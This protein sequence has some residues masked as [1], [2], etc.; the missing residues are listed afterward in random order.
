MFSLGISGTVYAQT[1]GYGSGDGIGDSV[2]PGDTPTSLA[3]LIAWWK[4]NSGIEMG[5]HEPR[6]GEC[7][8]VV[9]FRFDFGCNWDAGDYIPEGKVTEDLKIFYCAI[10]V[11]HEKITLNQR[12]DPETVTDIYWSF[13]AT[14]YY[15]CDTPTLTLTPS[16]ASIDVGEDS[17]VD[18]QINCFEAG[19]VGGMTVNLW[20]ET[21]S[22]GDLSEHEAT[23]DDSGHASVTFHSDGEG[24]ATVNAQVLACSKEDNTHTKDAS[25]Q[26]E[27]GGRKLQVDLIYIGEVTQ[28]I[29]FMSSFVHRMKIDIETADNG[30]VSGSGDGQTT[31]DFEY[32]ND[33]GE[34]Y[35]DNWSESGFTTCEA[36][37]TFDGET[38]TIN[39]DTTGNISFEHVVEI[40]G[41]EPIRIPIEESIDW[42][43]L[44]AEPV[45]IAADD[46]ATFSTSGSFS[47]GLTY[48]I[49]AK[50]VKDAGEG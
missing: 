27:V 48:I 32:E 44:L 17:T 31:F 26:I 30:I 6:F 50:W 3:N 40:P 38:Y 19:G 34:V 20:L 43:Q 41:Q 33:T 21:G 22:P 49:N 47:W 11:N 2:A 39:I 23:T 29:Q 5:D 7:K 16:P 9:G 14:V 1:D 18:I 36:E 13:Q 12:P 4:A 37:G 46:D 35:S 24:T 15:E 42:E 28:G 45:V 25:C 8:K 10:D